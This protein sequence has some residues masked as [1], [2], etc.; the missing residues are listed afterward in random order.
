MLVKNKELLQ[1]IKQEFSKDNTE[2]VLAHL[3]DD[4]K[5]NIV[6]M[7]IIV[8]KNEFIKTMKMF[9][10]WRSNE[11]ENF[12]SIKIKNVIAEGEY[13]VVESSGKFDTTAYCDIC[14][15][16]DGI[17]QEITTYVVDTTFNE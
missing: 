17:V 3:S 6:G 10:L 7:P 4:V 1:L 8:G 13:V 9:E 11:E 15:I 2:F 14:R 16:S 5:W 12:S